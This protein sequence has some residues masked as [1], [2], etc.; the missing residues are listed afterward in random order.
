M[1]VPQSYGRMRPE[2]CRLCR[3]LDVEPSC[4]VATGMVRMPDES[5]VLPGHELLVTTRHVGGL[6]YAAK[7]VVDYSDLLHQVART[8]SGAYTLV[9]HGVNGRRSQ[10]GCID[11]AHI[12]VFPTE[13]VS[14][15]K[16]LATSAFRF[17]VELPRVEVELPDLPYAVHGD[18]YVWLS[19][20][21]G[22][23]ALIQPPEWVPVPSQVARQSMAQSLGL[24]SWDWRRESALRSAIGRSSIRS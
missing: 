2:S 4:D 7:S 21:Q 8:F 12:H 16:L 15:G 24:R 1:N 11:H 19:D 22:K 18:E 23:T 13:E 17:A 14:V 9:E 6:A 5:P 10:P 20:C 3:A